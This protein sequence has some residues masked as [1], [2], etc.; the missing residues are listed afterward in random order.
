MRKF[1]WLL[2]AAGIIIACIPLAGNAY[3]RYR[4]QALNRAAEELIDSLGDVDPEGDY[5]A[6][7]EIFSEEAGQ[8]GA[9]ALQ[10][11]EPSTGDNEE[12]IDNT[13][14]TESVAPNPSKP[15]KKKSD[16][17]VLGKIKI[18]KIDV[19]SVIVEG[20]AKENLSVGIG[21]I[22]GTSKIG[23]VGNCALAGHRSY[24]FGRFF[25]RLN[26]LEIGDEISLITKE[27]SFIYKVYKKHIVEPDDVS[28]LKKSR[29]DRVLTLITCEPIFVATHRLI[30]HAK[31][32]N[33]TQNAD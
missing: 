15:S 10:N 19:D 5:A 17:I 16:Q 23:E 18:E 7:T 22:K 28:V 14:T 21:H 4:Q 24:T 2:I 11:G 12:T 3:I 26:E 13:G 25:N 29:T 27:G 6:L 9:A 31:L 33:D 20:V 1:S 8:G 30:I 32:E